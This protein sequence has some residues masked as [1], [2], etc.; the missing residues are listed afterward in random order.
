MDTPQ[1]QNQLQN[2]ANFIIYL[3]YLENHRSQITFKLNYVLCTSTFHIRCLSASES[4]LPTLHL[5]DIFISFSFATN[6]LNHKQNVAHII[7]WQYIAYLHNSI[8]IIVHDNFIFDK[9]NSCGVVVSVQRHQQQIW[10]NPAS[11][12]DKWLHPC[13]TLGHNYSSVI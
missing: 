4:G 2:G 7:L 12:M 1:L 10:A 3:I 6:K 8:A 13:T 5:N 11:S 9:G